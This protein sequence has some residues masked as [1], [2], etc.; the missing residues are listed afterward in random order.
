MGFDYT[1]DEHVRT[2][3]DREVLAHNSHAKVTTDVD[4]DKHASEPAV[5]MSIDT[6]KKAL[7][8]RHTFTS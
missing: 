6:L 1:S 2:V 8:V 7:A 4:A 5:D 3:F